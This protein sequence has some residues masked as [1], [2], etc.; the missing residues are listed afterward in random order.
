MTFKGHVEVIWGVKIIKPDLNSSFKLSSAAFTFWY[1]PNT[2]SS[3]FW[4]ENVNR[5]GKWTVRK[6]KLGGRAKIK[7]ERSGHLQQSGQ[8]KVAFEKTVQFNDINRLPSPMGHG[9]S[10]WTWPQ[11]MINVKW[12]ITS[13]ISLFFLFNFLFILAISFSLSRI[14]SFASDILFFYRFS[15]W[16]SVEVALNRKT[17]IS[18]SESGIK[19]ENAPLQ[20]FVR[21]TILL[22]VLEYPESIFLDCQAFA[23]IH[24]VVSSSPPKTWKI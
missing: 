2:G 17:L 4:N 15:I 1:V 20:S 14:S 16:C 18:Q 12:P 7:A 5:C 23:R 11:I 9:C 21:L 10:L 24:F 22:L 6:M 13:W 3:R 8:P 19:N